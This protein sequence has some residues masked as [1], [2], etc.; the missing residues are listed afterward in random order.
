M[1]RKVASDQRAQIDM[2]E[3]RW[4]LSGTGTPQQVLTEARQIGLDD[5][6]FYRD[7]GLL[8]KTLGNIEQQLGRDLQHAPSNPTLP[9]SVLEN[10]LK[11]ST[12]P[13]LSDISV[14]G[15][16][17]GKQ[18]WSDNEILI[19]ESQKLSQEHISSQPPVLEAD[20]LTVLITMDDL[21]NYYNLGWQPYFS[22]LHEVQN[23]NPADKKLTT[24]AAAD[25]A[26]LQV[27]VDK[28]QTDGQRLTIT[29]KQNLSA[30]FLSG[31]TVPGGT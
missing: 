26:K 3:P 13:L 12:T 5:R 6:S 8:Q 14:L 1:N 15:P 11:S 4:L 2:L 7:L 30:L 25:A 29:D 24:D 18:L 27:A 28:A 22:D 20:Y 21:A 9:A 17:V 23:Y 19:R 16:L 10:T 31:S